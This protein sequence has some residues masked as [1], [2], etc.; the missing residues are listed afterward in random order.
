[1]KY[2]ESGYTL[3]E[4]CV[5]LSI[6]ALLASLAV[7]NFNEQIPHRQLREASL[8]LVG[9]LRLARQKAISGGA[10]QSISFHSKLRQYNLFLGTR[11]LPGAVHFGS[12]SNVTKAPS[13]G[14]IVPQDGISFQ[15]DT[16]TFL[17]DGTAGKKG[18]IYLSNSKNESV[19]IAV[20]FT[21]RVKKY[22]WNGHDWE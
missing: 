1:M 5:V 9:Q 4:L 2:S 19:A 11:T 21:G 18:T 20:N 8:E 15:G 14:S 13:K 7:A 22:L 16:A 10:S 17:P 12:A 6:I 3:T